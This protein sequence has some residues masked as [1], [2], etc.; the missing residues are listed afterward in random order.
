MYA[1]AATAGVKAETDGRIGVVGEGGAL[2]EVEGGVGLAGGYDLDATSGE[3]GAEADVE[4]EVGGLFELAAIEVAASVVAT[5]GGVEEDDEAGDGLGWGLRRLR[6]RRRLAD[7]GNSE[8]D[9]EKEAG[10]E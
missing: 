7:A 8:C 10:G 5:V 9:G 2:V 1:R 4:G 3:Q 6:G